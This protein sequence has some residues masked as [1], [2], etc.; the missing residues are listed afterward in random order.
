LLHLRCRR[1]NHVVGKLVQDTQRTGDRFERLAHGWS[2][3]RLSLQ[4]AERTSYCVQCNGGM[5]GGSD[6]ATRFDLMKGA[7][8][9]GYRF[10]GL[11][12]GG[13][14]ARGLQRGQSLSQIFAG[15]ARCTHRV[16]HRQFASLTRIALNR[17]SHVPLSLTNLEFL[18]AWRVPTT[19]GQ[20][21]CQ[22]TLIDTPFIL[23]HCLSSRAPNGKPK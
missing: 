7:H 1:S 17:S 2:I 12:Y 4:Y 19:L 20:Q 18:L 9:L 8:G 15:A 14:N 10:G 3:R 6:T 23:Q 16:T 5:L 11:G 21:A 13:R 22:F